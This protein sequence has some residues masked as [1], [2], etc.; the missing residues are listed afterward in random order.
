MKNKL[1]KMFKITGISVLSLA[2]LPFALTAAVLWL[3]V[4]SAK[5]MVVSVGGR[6]RKFSAEICR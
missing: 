6:R 1:A 2:A 4:T 5:F 3:A